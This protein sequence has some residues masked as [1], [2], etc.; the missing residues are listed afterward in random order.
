[1]ECISDIAAHNGA[2]KVLQALPNQKILATACDK[3]IAL[4]DLVSMTNIGYLK[5]HKD[6]IRCL[7]KGTNLLVSAGRS[8][9]ADPSIFLWDLRSLQPVESL[10][11]HSD[12]YSVKM[13]ENDQE[14]YVGNS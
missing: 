10:E 1:M 5:S 9:T 11:V 14:L 13:M 3:V 7:E 2:I 6:E 4:W 12:I 8:T